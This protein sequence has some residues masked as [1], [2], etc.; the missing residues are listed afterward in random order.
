[1]DRILT[2]GCLCGAV[3]FSVKDE[4]R[5]FFFCHCEQCRKMTGSAYASNLF[6]AP[7]NLTWLQGEGE[8]RRF[9]LPGRQLSQVFCTHCGSALP[10]VTQNGKALIVPAGTLDEE[11][12]RTP[13]AQIFCS[14]ETEWHKAGI[15]AKRYPEFPR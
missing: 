4:F 12:S 2:G 9:D 3:R 6:T 1:M 14:E 5:R 15:D 10:F 7:E 8:T 11:P 13:D